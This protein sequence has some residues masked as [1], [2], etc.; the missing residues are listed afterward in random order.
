[1][2]DNI[3]DVESRAY[4]RIILPDW[5]HTPQKDPI[6]AGGYSHTDLDRPT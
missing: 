3:K 4:R 1:M 6:F 5:W 2:F